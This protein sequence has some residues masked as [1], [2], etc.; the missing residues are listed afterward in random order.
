MWGN[1]TGQH[2]HST[3]TELAAVLVA[4]LRPIPLHIA[5][6]SQAMIDKANFLMD[7]AVL[8]QLRMGSEHWTT[9]NPCKKAW[10]LQKDGDLWERFWAASLLRGPRTLR[11]TKVK[12]H[13]GMKQ[14]EEGIITVENMIGNDFSDTA[15]TR[16]TGEG[17]PGLL[18][19]ASWLSDQ[20]DQY[21]KWMKRVLSSL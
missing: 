6:D 7:Q 2:S 11:L 21:C 9:V 19:L 1:M 10:G 4:M 18:G 5:S 12:A 8:W 15:A 14:V 16:G 13:C 3:R 20:H 17:M